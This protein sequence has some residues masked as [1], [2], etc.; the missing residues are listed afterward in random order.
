M[1]KPTSPAGISRT[2]ID[3][4]EQTGADVFLDILRNFGVEYIFSSPGTE[5]A[6]LWESLARQKA[7]GMAGPEF[8]V[9]RHED[10]AI[11]MAT[12][13]SK[14]TGKLSICLVH[15]SVGTFRVGMGVR[16][17]YQEHVPM[18]VCAGEA[19][20]LGEGDNAWVGFHWGRYLE[21]YGGPARILEPV[22]KSTFA[23]NAQP[24]LAASA[25]RACQLAMASPPGPVFLSLPF[26]YMAGVAEC[27]APPVD[28]FP[29]Q[30]QVNAQQLAAVAEVLASSRS[31]VIITEKI[32]K[33]AQAVADLVTLAESINAVVVEAQHP[34]YVNFPRKHALHGGFNAAPY[35]H[36]ADVV[37]LLDM[38][39]PAWYPE[40]AMRP[41]QA[42]IIAIG[43]DPLRARVPYHAAAADIALAGRADDAVAALIALLPEG[44]PTTGERRT[45]LKTAND[46]RRDEW[47]AMAQQHAS[48]TPIDA[49][50]LCEE[51]NTALPD[52]AIL[53][54][55]TI[56]TNFTMLHVMD[57]LKPGQFINAMNGGLGTGLGAALGVK[58]ANP[59]RPVIVMLGDGGFNYN[60]PLAAVGFCQEYQCPITVIICDNGRW[61]A[62]QMVT[63]QLYPDG[64]A[65][66]TDN[67]YGSYIAPQINYASMA[68]MVG[69][70]GELITE[71]NEIKPAVQRA[72]K[73]NA[74]GRVAILDVIIGDE[75]DYLGPM[76]KDS[77]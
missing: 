35:L 40:T 65:K 30:P 5:W 37:L 32:G 28:G 51:L 58:V 2:A 14:A 1:D 34:E 16:G 8:L 7:L 29:A 3:T 23:L 68:G 9:A 41:A 39:G 52:N 10:L 56:L 18:L 12:G 53:V 60:P 17:A 71:P 15:C 24:L 46:A 55:E 36:D 66:Q 62:M 70:H 48:T 75:M 21:D 43:E 38:I 77:H 25:H 64:H 74:D 26:E 6:P 61:R 44:E 22:V 49:R 13:Y 76:M 19:I 57:A 20:T 69:G 73:A 72:L 63:E 4:Q 33:S 47:H 54:D 50:W 31:P 11:G 27:A 67:Y 42:K 45:T 59:E